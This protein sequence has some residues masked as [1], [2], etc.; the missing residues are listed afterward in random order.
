MTS[1]NTDK[2]ENIISFCYDEFFLGK[3]EKGCFE[4]VD[5]GTHSL[6]MF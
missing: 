2:Y 4:G 6:V 5:Y 3:V 1:I